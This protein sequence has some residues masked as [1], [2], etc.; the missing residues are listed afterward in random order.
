MWRGGRRGLTQGPEEQQQDTGPLKAFC[1]SFHSANYPLTTETA[2][3]QSKEE[4]TMGRILDLR[5]GL[6]TK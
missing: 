3:L 6:V 4:A 1:W 5:E 2:V